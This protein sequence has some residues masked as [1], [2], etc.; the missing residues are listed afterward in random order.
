[1]L[2]K[3]EGKRIDLDTA[4]LL[5]QGNNIS[6]FNIDA[7]NGKINVEIELSKD[8]NSEPLVKLLLKN[9]SSLSIDEFRWPLYNDGMSIEDISSSGME[10]CNWE[11]SDY[12][13]GKLKAIA[14]VLAVEEIKA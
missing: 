11:L 13:E 14:E 2:V 3:D 12:E 10:D 6:V 1:M 4:A 5:K 7:R 9:V 8:E